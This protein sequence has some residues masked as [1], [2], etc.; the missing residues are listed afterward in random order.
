MILTQ[1]ESLERGNRLKRAVE[2]WCITTDGFDDSLFEELIESMSVGD[3]YIIFHF[4]CGLDLKEELYI[5][6]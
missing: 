5:N 3:D 4:R 2:D 6:D 1:S